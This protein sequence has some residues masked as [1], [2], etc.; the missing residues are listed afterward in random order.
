MFPQYQKG[1]KEIV[2]GKIPLPCKPGFCLIAAGQGRVEG[3]GVAGLD[4]EPQ[5][6][7]YSALWIC[8]ARGG[9]GEC[10]GWA[11]QIGPRCPRDGTLVDRRG[12][13]QLDINCNWIIGPSGRR[14]YGRC[15]L[16]TDP[17]GSPRDSLE[18]PSCGYMSMVLDAGPLRAAR[19]RL[20][21]CGSGGRWPW[22][23]ACVGRAT[24]R[25]GE[26][27]GARGG[28]AGGEQAVRGAEGQMQTGLRGERGD[29][30][31]V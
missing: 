31:S 5:C 28:R 13:P 27:A 8:K 6:I 17:D 29:K 25:C 2:A 4:Y 9:G 18:P 10:P 23:W 24:Q 30:G 1:K 15:G 19:G 22:L 12:I 7:T 14:A 16:V 21:H 11:L 20:F 3:G 26:R